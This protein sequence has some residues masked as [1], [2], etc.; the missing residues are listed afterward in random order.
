MR[1][2]N[3]SRRLKRSSRATISLVYSTAVR[4]VG[5][6]HL[7][8]EVAQAVFIILARKAGSLGSKTIL[9]SPLSTKHVTR[10]TSLAPLDFQPGISDLMIPQHENPTRGVY[11]SNGPRKQNPCP[12]FPLASM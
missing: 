4:Q 12:V 8:Q 1:S 11:L 10:K 6:P 2:T 5:D 9:P 7:A 3:P